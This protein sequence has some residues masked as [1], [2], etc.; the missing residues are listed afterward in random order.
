MTRSLLHVATDRLGR[1]LPH[2]ATTIAVMVEAGADVHP[3]FAEI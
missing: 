2:V 3:R 1:P